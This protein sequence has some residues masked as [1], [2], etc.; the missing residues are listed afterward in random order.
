MGR[1]MRIA[2]SLAIVI[3]VAAPASG[4][5]LRARSVAAALC[6]GTQTGC[7]GSIQAAV[8]AAHDGDTI[9]IGPGTFGGGV[10]IAESVHVIGSG[11]GTTTING[12]GPVVTIGLADAATQP[13]VRLSGLTIAGGLNTSGPEAR[14]GGIAVLAGA[15][16]TLSSSVVTGNRVAPASN[17]PSGLPCS[18]LCPYALASGAGINNAG[19][20]VL[21]GVT[22]TGNT[23]SGPMTSDADGGGIMNER[24]ATLLVRDSV[25]T[26]N[27]ARAVLPYGRFAEAGGIFSRSTSSLTV[28]GSSVSGNTAELSTAFSSAVT[29]AQ[30]GGV[31]LAQREGETTIG[32]IRDSHIDGNTVIATSTGGELFAFGGGI[33]GDGSLLLVG[34]TVDDNRVDASS[35][36]N[37]FADGGGLEI[38]G[39]ATIAGTHIAGNSVT[40]H[41]AQGIASAQAGG[42]FA[43]GETPVWVRDSFIGDNTA[44]STATAGTAIVQGGGILNATGLDVRDSIVRDNTAS[45]AGPSG[46]AQGGGIWNGDLDYGPSVELA[47]RNVTVT[48]NTLSGTPGLPVQGGGLFT[49]FPVTLHDTV[50][51]GNA[52]DQC[53]GC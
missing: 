47:L 1:L 39:S 43:A 21:N 28:V 38:E 10:T 23:A 32:T 18:S 4:A 11:A 50:L 52:P 51:A 16:L 27:L 12:G 33:D 25:V 42:L 31:K 2:G 6:V 53:F 44:H 8:D 40:A 20:T 17:R 9:T 29:G 15:S 7:Y 19:T 26:G 45:A 49:A 48:D 14:G 22:V 34:S 37:M 46:T 3:A 36:E 30:S 13:T 35:N 5:A 24:G 41:A